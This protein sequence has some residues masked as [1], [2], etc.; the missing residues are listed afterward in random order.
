M[1]AILSTPGWRPSGSPASGP[2]PGHDVEHA[3][4]QPRLRRQLGEQERR[5]RRLLGGLE[6]D[7]V[8]GRE[9]RPELPGRDDERVVPRHDRADDAERLALHERHRFRTDGRQLAAPLVDGLAV[10]AQARCGAR[11]VDAQRVADRLADVEGLEQG[12][13]VYAR[14]DEVGEAQQDAAALG[15]RRPAPG[16]AVEGAAA[17]AHGAVDVLGA[18]AGD[19]GEVAAVA[20]TVVG[21]RRPVGRRGEGAVDE[22][23][24]TRADRLGGRRARGMG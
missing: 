1:K 8:A 7:A 13:V 20:G 24:G 15:G 18:A 17:G 21:E 23:V 14:L 19:V 16:P 22:R 3:V 5:Q 2:R 6:D 9:R 11:D 4:R 10:E 12:E